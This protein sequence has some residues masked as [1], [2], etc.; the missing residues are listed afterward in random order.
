MKFNEFLEN[1]LNEASISLKGK[2]IT[3]LQIE[4]QTNNYIYIVKT[5]P[6]QAL[7]NFQLKILEINGYNFLIPYKNE[8]SNN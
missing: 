1:E 5:M 7:I 3:D 4:F 6:N 2:T 8:H